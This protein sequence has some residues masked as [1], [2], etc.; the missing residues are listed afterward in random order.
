M[1]CCHLQIIMY[2]HSVSSPLGLP[3]IIVIVTAALEIEE[4]GGEKLVSNRAFICRRQQIIYRIFKSNSAETLEFLKIN[5]L[6][7]QAMLI[8]KSGYNSIT[9][10]LEVNYVGIR[11]TLRI[12]G[13]GLDE[14]LKFKSH[15]IVYLNLF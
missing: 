10:L 1:P 12:L 4:Y 9:L 8:V 11:D 14:Q 15:I 13:V 6:K 2:F 3:A 5:T 7:T